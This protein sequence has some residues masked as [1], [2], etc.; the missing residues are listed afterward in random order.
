VSS[1][2]CVATCKSTSRCERCVCPCSLLILQQPVSSCGQL[3]SDRWLVLGGP[4][5]LPSCAHKLS[6]S[7]AWDWSQRVLHELWHMQCVHRQWLSV[8]GVLCVALWCWLSAVSACVVIELVGHVLVGAE[9]VDTVQSHMW[10]RTA[11]SDCSVLVF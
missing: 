1:N 11:A 6:M 2:P 4:H 10:R 8:S 7:G 9:R 3:V 5:W